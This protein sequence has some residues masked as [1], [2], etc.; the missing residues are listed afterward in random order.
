MKKQNVL[1]H[2]YINFKLQWREWSWKD[3]KYKIYHKTVNG[4]VPG[5]YT[6]GTANF[7]GDIG[8]TGGDIVQNHD[9]N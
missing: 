7:T 8:S 2:V 6:V 4:I 9:V 5:K 1:L 3:R